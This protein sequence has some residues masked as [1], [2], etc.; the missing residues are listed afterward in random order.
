MID[1]IA[2]ILEMRRR[3]FEAGYADGDKV[4]MLANKILKMHG[5]QLGEHDPALVDRVAK[6]LPPLCSVAY[7]I[8]AIDAVR[9]YDREHAEPSEAD[10][11]AE[12]N[13]VIK[14]MGSGDYVPHAW[15]GH[16]GDVHMGASG[17]CAGVYYVPNSRFGEHRAETPRAALMALR[18]AVKAN[19]GEPA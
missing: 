18:D 16:H 4:A 15:C 10:L 11:I 1:D 3:A 12:I 19:E 9:A 6:T 7:A 8:A 2:I 5:E 17:W 14:D 13:E